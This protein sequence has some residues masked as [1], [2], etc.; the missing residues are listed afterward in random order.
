MASKIAISGAT[1]EAKKA[2]RKSQMENAGVSGDE[3]KKLRKL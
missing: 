2:L 3:F 1:A